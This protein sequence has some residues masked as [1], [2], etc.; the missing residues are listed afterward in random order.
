MITDGYYIFIL[1]GLIMF[2]TIYYTHA[3]DLLQKKCVLIVPGHPEG[4]FVC[5]THG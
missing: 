2:D 4:A 3:H 5:R 1:M